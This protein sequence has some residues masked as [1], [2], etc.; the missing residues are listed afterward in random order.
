MLHFSNEWQGLKCLIAGI[1]NDPILALLMVIC[2]DD[3]TH[4]YAV[5]TSALTIAFS[6]DLDDLARN[7]YN[8]PSSACR[9]NSCRNVSET[10]S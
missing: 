4:Q 3:Q 6:T 10:F 7:I 5:A 1:V 2:F 9:Y 8:L